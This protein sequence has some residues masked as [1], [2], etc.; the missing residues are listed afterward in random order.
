[1]FGCAASPATAA[2]DQTAI[3]KGYASCRW[4]LKVCIAITL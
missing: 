1:V 4:P 3:M 2:N